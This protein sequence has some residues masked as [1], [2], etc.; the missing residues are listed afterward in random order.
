L[1]QRLSVPPPNVTTIDCAIDPDTKR[2]TFDV[3]Y[4]AVN[5]EAGQRM[6]SVTG[7]T[8]HLPTEVATALNVVAM[9]PEEVDQ[10]SPFTYVMG[11]ART[12]VANAAVMPPKA[13]PP[14][15]KPKPD[16]GGAPLP[17]TGTSPPSGLVV[18][19]LFA[20]SVLAWRLRRLA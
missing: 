12:Q 17:N 15:A 7:G 8:Y 18:L 20:A 3:P 2:I 11:S 6:Y 9:L 14:G 1:Y 10:T 16:V 19:V 4:A 13:A 5:G